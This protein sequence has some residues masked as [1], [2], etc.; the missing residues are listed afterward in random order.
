MNGFTVFIIAVLLGLIPAAI[1]QNK[2]RSFVLWWIFGALLFIVALPAALLIKL[3]T[4]KVE[5][6]KMQSGDMKK[7]PYCA[8]LIKTEANVCRYC[9]KELPSLKSLTL[10]LETI[11]SEKKQNPSGISSD[12]A[13][14][15]REGFHYL[16]WSDG[17]GRNTQDALESAKIDIASLNRDLLLTVYT[18]SKYSR[19]T[20]VWFND[21]DLSSPFT[22]F[23]ATSTKIIFVKPAA[24]LVVSVK[25]ID[26]KEIEPIKYF[27]NETYTIST[28]SE[29]KVKAT[30][31]FGNQQ[32]ETFIDLFFERLRHIA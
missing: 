21:T 20:E 29:N 13:A 32:H 25:F 4:A 12:E 8:E 3:D 19:I 14:K 15:W 7:C 28:F 30:M 31:E 11:V 26:I 10:D 9:G 22:A 2:G 16:S 18:D 17:I 6:E 27:N 23:I 5:E 1:A 24:N